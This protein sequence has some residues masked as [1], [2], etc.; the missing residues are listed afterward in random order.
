MVYEAVVIDQQ[1]EYYAALC[2]ETPA[3]SARTDELA[4][5]IR[6]IS[7]NMPE[8]WIGLPINNGMIR[9]ASFE[10]LSNVGQAPM[11]L[12]SGWLP[13]RATIAAWLS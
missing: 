8:R 11:S 5:T 4:E 9:A 7:R 3:C 10:S 12:T 2:A 1:I 6:N 13:R